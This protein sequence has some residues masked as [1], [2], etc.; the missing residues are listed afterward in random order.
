MTPDH[1]IGDTQR[2][3]QGVS[4]SDKENIFDNL[5]GLSKR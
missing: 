1:L 4:P 2:S 5:V 3:L